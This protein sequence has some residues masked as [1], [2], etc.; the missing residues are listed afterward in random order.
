MRIEK[1]FIPNIFVRVCTGRKLGLKELKKFFD[2]IKIFQEK[3]KVTINETLTK[4]NKIMWDAAV[5]QI[6]FQSPN[7][8]LLSTLYKRAEDVLP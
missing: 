8:F 3:F 6:F 7:I 1:C 4:T 2:G 5:T